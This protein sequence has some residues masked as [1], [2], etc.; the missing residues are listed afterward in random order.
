[1]NNVLLDILPTEWNGYKVNTWFQVGIQLLMIQ[2]D[3]TLSE[4]EKIELYLDLLFS[5]DDGLLR[6]HP[7]GEELAQCVGWFLTGWNHDRESK[8]KQ[9]KRLV[10]YDVDQWRIYADFRQIYNIDLK[11]SNMHFWEFMGLLWNMP[12]KSSSFIQVIEIR[13]KE[14]TST[15]SKEEKKAIQ[16]AQSVYA[17]EDNKV[18][19]YSIEEVS[20]IDEFDRFMEE[21]NKKRS[22]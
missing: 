16:E 8:S 19:E 18:K 13:R 10:D 7:I 9:N 20:A 2:D 1:M 4:F 17:L 6:K 3:Y 12:Y 21:I 5:N 14:I 15:T 22:N 11:E